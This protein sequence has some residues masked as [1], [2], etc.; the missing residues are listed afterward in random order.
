MFSEIYEYLKRGPIE[1]EFRI[2][3]N[4]IS[5]KMSNFRTLVQKVGDLLKGSFWRNIKERSNFWSCLNF[6]K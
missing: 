6:L 3:A 1:P 5:K 4:E 2:M